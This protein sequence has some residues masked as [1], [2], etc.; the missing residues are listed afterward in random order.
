MVKV[1]LGG[2]ATSGLPRL[3]GSTLTWAVALPGCGGHFLL[4]NHRRY[5]G[6]EPRRR[7]SVRHLA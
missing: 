5:E 1:R 2:S 4:Y 6:I 7:A 3:G